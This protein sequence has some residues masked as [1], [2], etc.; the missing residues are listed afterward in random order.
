MS[1]KPRKKS[2]DTNFNNLD[3]ESDYA[4]M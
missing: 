3:W 2:I 1:D 4:H